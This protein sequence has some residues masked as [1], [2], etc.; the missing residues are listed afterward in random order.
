MNCTA[1]GTSLPK[2]SRFCS[3][4]GAKQE[5]NV[6]CMECGA[7]LPNDARFCLSCGTA[8]R[9]ATSR[10]ASGAA[11]PVVDRSSLSGSGG[12]SPTNPDDAII[13]RQ[14]EQLLRLPQYRP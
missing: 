10:E 9:Q 12:S 6:F 13:L 1:C 14:L 7:T 11:S 8:V 3:S 2:D 5:L 4:C